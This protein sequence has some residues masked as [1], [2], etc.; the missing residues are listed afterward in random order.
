M[1]LVTLAEADAIA[2]VDGINGLHTASHITKNSIISIQKTQIR[3]GRNKTERKQNQA[4]VNAPWPQR[5]EYA[6]KTTG[7]EE[8]PA[9]C[10]TFL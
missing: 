6:F 10:P 9:C 8:I 2:L 7:G 1:P 4:F 3:Q 5:L